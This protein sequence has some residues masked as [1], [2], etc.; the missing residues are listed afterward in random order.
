MKAWEE[1]WTVDPHDETRVREP[2]GWMVLE[3]FGVQ[4]DAASVDRARLAAR[5]PEMAR[6]LLNVGRW[7]SPGLGEQRLPPTKE[8]VEAVLRDA[9]VIP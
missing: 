9:G 2:G 3:A 1:T 8:E 7:L 4:V 5:A 6:L